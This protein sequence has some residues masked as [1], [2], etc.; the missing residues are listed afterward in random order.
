VGRNE[1]NNRR[2]WAKLP[3]SCVCVY[4]CVCMRARARA[5]VCVSKTWRS[6]CDR[7]TEGSMEEERT[8]WRLC[9]D[10]G[11]AICDLYNPSE[12]SVKV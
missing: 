6:F 4:V 1:E 12:I 2:E 7:R 3:L 8:I 9:K 11:E 5:R 10:F